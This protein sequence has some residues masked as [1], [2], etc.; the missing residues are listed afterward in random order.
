L[1]K[2]PKNRNW[3]LDFNPWGEKTDPLLFDW[4]DLASSSNI[5]DVEYRIIEN[6]HEV[7]DRGL[8]VYKVPIV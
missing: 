3:L 6:A 1:D 8:S 4:N 5:K 7:K 2:P